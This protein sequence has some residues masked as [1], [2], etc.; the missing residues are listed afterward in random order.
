MNHLSLKW[1]KFECESENVF[2]SIMTSMIL[3]DGTLLKETLLKVPFRLPLRYDITVR[4]RGKPVTVIMN[5]LDTVIIALFRQQ[6][7]KLFV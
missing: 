7:I 2:G 1:S 5:W 4:N 3:F 6:E